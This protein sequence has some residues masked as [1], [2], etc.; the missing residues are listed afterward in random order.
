MTLLL[1][2]AALLLVCMRTGEAI[3]DA[4][5]LKMFLCGL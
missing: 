1:F 2:H 4:N 3:S 5:G